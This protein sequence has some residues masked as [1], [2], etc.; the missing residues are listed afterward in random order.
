LRAGVIGEVGAGFS[1]F[2]S[3]T[4]SFL[5]LAGVNFAG[6]PLIPQRGKQIEYGVK[7][8]PDR[9][10]L[11][12][13]TGFHIRET[14]RPVY[15]AG[16]AIFQSGRLTTKGFEIEAS[17]QLGNNYELLIN[18]G[19][20]KVANDGTVAV[21]FL[22]RNNASAWGTKT[23][24]LGDDMTLRF[25]AGVR[26]TGKRQSGTIV[27]NDNTLID[28]LAELNWQKW[29]FSINA[30]NLFDEKFYASCLAR[31]D[32]FVGAPRNVMG[33]VAYRF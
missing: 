10:T 11:I 15:G 30:T 28:A 7:W 14:N 3:Y 12:T 6:D 5:P 16:S 33:T 23:F 26:Y 22:P 2:A 25:G 4:E 32:C 1:P 9:A 31:G 13:V 21:D 17:R 29:R 24:P 19:Y 27:T 8:Q 18:Y 20:N